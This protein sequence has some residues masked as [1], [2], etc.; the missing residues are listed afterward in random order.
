MA[1]ILSHKQITFYN[2]RLNEK[3]TYFTQNGIIVNFTFLVVY[4]K[5]F[6]YNR[7]RKKKRK[8]E[9]SEKYIKFMYNLD[10]GFLNMIHKMYNQSISIILCHKSIFKR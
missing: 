4:Y 6:S 7:I 8:L 1:K 5:S 9:T 3:N 2:W 10:V